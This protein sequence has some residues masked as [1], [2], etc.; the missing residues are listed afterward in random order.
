MSVRSVLLAASAALVLAACSQPEPAKEAPPAAP[1]RPAVMSGQ[2]T[3]VNLALGA[4][5]SEKSELN[6]AD[7]IDPKQVGA[8]HT[9][10]NPPGLLLAEGTLRIPTTDGQVFYGHEAGMCVVSAPGVDA[11]AL[12]D[13]IDRAMALPAFKA[14]R[15]ERA[16]FTANGVRVQQIDYSLELDPT[17]LHGP[18]IMMRAPVSDRAGPVAIA[19]DNGVQPQ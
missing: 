15:M 3:A 4:C 1:A 6:R 9:G 16:P 7:A 5:L 14:R 19:V 2:D 8:P 10:A 11:F 12:R 13:R 17:K 18:F